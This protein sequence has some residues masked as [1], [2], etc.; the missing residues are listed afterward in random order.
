MK[1]YFYIFGY[2]QRCR[3]DMCMGFIAPYLRLE[4]YYCYAATK[5]ISSV[6][7]CCSFIIV[8]DYV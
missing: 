6:V 1:H 8:I 2:S 7:E 3:L 5:Q 4:T